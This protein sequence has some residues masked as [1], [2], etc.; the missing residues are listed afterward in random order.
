MNILS[1]CTLAQISEEKNETLLVFEDFY[2]GE[3]RLA[4]FGEQT[5]H[6]F[7]IDNVLR[8][9]NSLPIETRSG[10]EES[11]ITPTHQYLRFTPSS[12]DQLWA[13]QSR[14][15]I[16]LYQYPLDCDISGG[17]VGIENPFEVD[18]FP[19]YWCILPI[20]Y[21]LECIDCPFTLESYLWIPDLL[22]N[23]GIMVRSTF[24][25]YPE[26]L[27]LSIVATICKENNIEYEDLIPTRASQKYY[28]KG[29]IKYDDSELGKIGVKGMVVEA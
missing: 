24:S 21:C 14:S 4:S 2:Q 7:S 11:Q 25:S 13:I 17:F 29:S 12:D 5:G 22:D 9:I 19:Q 28:P 10:V 23:E 15:E 6:P 20:D 16:D 18:G 1:S 26:Q 8:V 3:L 27:V